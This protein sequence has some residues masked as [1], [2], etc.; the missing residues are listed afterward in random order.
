MEI[1]IG[2]YKNIVFFD[3][4]TTG[5]CGEKE[6]IIELAAVR[7]NEKGIAE[8]DEFIRLPEGKKIPPEITELTHITDVM[9]EAQGKSEEAVMTMFDELISGDGTLLIAHNAQFDLNFIGWTAARHK[10][11]HPSWIR[12]IAKADYLDTLTIYKD[13]RKYPHKLVNAIEE[14]GLSD[15]V[16]NSHRAVDDCRALVEV[17]KAMQAER[18]D[19]ARYVNIFG[20]NPKYGVS[21]SKYKKVTYMPH[22]GRPYMA[23]PEQ[24]LPALAKA[25]NQR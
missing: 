14:Y 24:I 1:K 15:K 17:L 11:Q 25:Y 16:Q 6:N 10:E 12:N 13:R 7:I 8:M 9:R 5:F 3:T 19:V 4:E 2:D 21:G 23:L 18:D 22:D 20:Y